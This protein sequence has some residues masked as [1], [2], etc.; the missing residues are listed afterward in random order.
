M[1][2]N[3]LLTGGA[4]YIGSSVAYFLIDQGHEV[5]VVDSLVTGNRKLVP[6][7]ANFKLCDISDQKEISSIINNS[8][9]DIVMHFAGLIR[10]DESIKEPEK[11]NEYNF[12]KAK[13]FFDTCFK[14]NLKKVVFSS[15]ASI[16]GNPKNNIVNEND[17]LKPINPY[18]LSKYNLERY[19]IE[20][21]KKSNI[22]FI[23][24]RY[25]NVAGAE[26]KMR[27]GLVSK[28]STHLIKVACE[29]ATKKRKKLIINGNDYDTV[30]GTPVRDFI[31]ISDLS[32][33]HLLSALDLV[34]NEKSNIFNCGYGKGFSVLQ[35]I[36][37][38]NKNLGYD[39]STSFGNRRD[40]DIASIV[41]NSKKFFNYFSWSP[42]YQNLSLI[43]KSSL[44]WEN[45]IKK[46]DN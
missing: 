35:V 2:L 28:H 12:T 25:F 39:I 45:K 37:V 42:K 9:F 31:H 18:A 43:L 6:E 22:K 8:K 4:G 38:L 5:T 24:L 33:M 10:V 14:N 21:S 32:E 30:D 13:V 19:L 15:T 17:E 44:E 20:Q 26:D 27:T 40:G 41:A 34:K 1:G 16:Y 3:I 7:K 29:V 11:Y 46:L 23:I 36:N